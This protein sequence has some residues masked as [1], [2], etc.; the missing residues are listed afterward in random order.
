MPT[1]YEYVY[2]P[3]RSEIVNVDSTVTKIEID[4]ESALAT[5]IASEAILAQDW[6]SPEDEEAWADL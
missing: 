3:A 4:E 1:S 5:M 6:D 2:R